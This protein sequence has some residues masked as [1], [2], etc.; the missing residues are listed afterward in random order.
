MKQII[1]YLLDYIKKDFNLKLYL[2]VAVF[3]AI[4]FYL[5]YEMGLARNIFG[6]YYRSPQLYLNYFLFVTFTY[7]SILF[8]ES[9]IRKDFHPFK[10]R[11]FLKF[12]FIGLVLLAVDGSSYYLFRSI[13]KFLGV[14]GE[15][16][17]WAGALSANIKRLLILGLFLYIFKKVFDKEAESFY[18]LTLKNFNWKPYAAMLLM[19]M[20]LIIM[21]SYQQSFLQ[22]YPIYKPGIAE[23][24]GGLSHWITVGSFEL[25]YGSRFIAV[26]LFFRGFLIIGLARLIGTRAILPMVVVYA[27]WHFSK[28]L[29]EAISSI[30]GGYILAIIALKSRTVFGGVLIH[31]GVALSMELM[32][33]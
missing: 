8:L 7:F 23:N 14:S 20:P 3:L 10:N 27:F 1:R 13:A 17:P 11:E 12:I 4:F 16:L 22:K 19:I 18:G 31:M 21:A 26:E 30:F 25:S 28:P 33:H 2:L 29:P 32:A 15:Y 5:N 6:K 9:L 24:H